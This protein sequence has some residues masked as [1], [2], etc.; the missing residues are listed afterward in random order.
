ML[1]ELLLEIFFEEYLMERLESFVVLT[2]R[3]I[4]IIVLKVIIMHQR[5]PKRNI[6]STRGIFVYIT[7]ILAICDVAGFSLQLP[8]FKVKSM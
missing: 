7:V 1:G 8:D 5:I 3:R 6:Y 2:C 4:Y